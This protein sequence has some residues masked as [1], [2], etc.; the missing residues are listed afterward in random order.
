MAYTNPYRTH[1]CNDIGEALIGQ[2]VRVAGWVENI[3]DHGGVLFIDLRDHYAVVQVVVHNE[4]G[5]WLSIVGAE[6][7]AVTA[8]VIF[9]IAK[10]RKFGY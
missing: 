1:T 10:R 6:F 8:T 7:M 3:R 2:T 4:D 5:I 9:L